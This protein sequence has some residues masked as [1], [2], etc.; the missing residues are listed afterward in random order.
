MTFNRLTTRFAMLVSM[1]M[2]LSVNLLAQSPQGTITG[3]VSDAQGARV[4]NATVNVLRVATNQKFTAVSSEEGVY[5]IPSLPIGEYEVTVTATGF[6]TYKQPKVVLEVGQRLRVDITMQ[7]GEM[8]NTVT[9][10]GDVSRVQ[11]EASSLGTTVERQRIEN[12]PLNGRHV[13]NLVKLVPGVQPRF[14]GSDGFAEVDNQSF[15]QISFNGGSAYS[16]QVFL[17]GG[18]NTVP[19]H[20]EISVVPIAD[21]VEEFKVQTNSLTAEYGQTSGGVISVATRSGTND[22]H[23]S[24]YEF[25]RNDSLDARNAFLTTR[26]PITGRIK[27]ILRYN[28]YGGTF[29][30]PLPLPRFGEGG[31]AIRSGK[32]RTFFFAGIEQWNHRQAN[33]NR[34]TVPTALERRGDFSNT[35]DGNGKLITIYDPATTRPNPNGSGFVRDPFPNNIIP[36]NRL[37]ALSLRILQYLPLPNVAPNNAFTNANN[38]LSLIG[39]PTDQFQTSLRIDHNIGEKDKIFGRYTGTK[40]TRMNRAWNNGDADTDARNDQRNNFNLILSHTHIFSNTLINELRVNGTRQF[41]DF[42]HPSF[43]KGYPAQLGFPA[44]IPQDA[45]PAII[46]DGVLPFGSGRGGFAG[47]YRRQHT[48]QVA[49]SVTWTK[50]AHVFKFGTDQR[51]NRFNFANRV[52]PSGSFNFSGSL[53]NNPLVPA[54]SG[55]GFASYLLGEVSG[56]SLS[57]R[58]FFA[59]QTASNGSFIQDDWKVTRRL[60]LNLGVRYDYATGPIER[61]NRSSN[62]DPFVINPLTNTPGALL[63]AGVTKDTHFTTPPRDNFGPRVGFAW[64]VKGDGKTAIRGGFGLIYSGIESGDTAGD[65]ANSLGFSI[66]TT[67]VAA[68]G[69]PVKAF[70]FSVGPPSLLQPRGSAGGP[71][72]F[73]GQNV[74]YQELRQPTPY[75]QQWN[76]T[77]QRELPGKWVLAATYAGNH[78]VHLFGGNYDLNQLDPKY[79]SLGLTL[80]DQVPNPYVGIIKAG[81]LSG[82]TVARSQ[83]LRP[84]PDYLNVALLANHGASSTYH[85]FQFTGERRYSNGLSALVS[86]TNSKLI[87][88]SFSIAGGGGGAGD[89]RIGRLNRKQDRAIDEEDI[90]QRLVVSAVYELPFG[91]GRRFVQGGFVSHVIGG[92]QINTITTLQT[93]RPLKVR[94]ANNFTG[95]N[96]PN[97]ACD[98]T[99]PSGD[100]TANRWFKTECFVN[101]PN[102]VIGNVPRTL[103]STRGPGYK[104]VAL[105]FFR[106]E[107][108]T[109]KVN[110]EFRAEAFNA[111]NF[112]NYDDPNTSFTPNALGVNSNANFG[113]IT[114]SLPARRIQLGLRL[115]F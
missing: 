58:P 82:A 49:D 84:F 91:K 24:L 113:K 7:V 19:V 16:N 63:Y 56:G 88:D 57:S 87:D 52:N 115:S 37:D 20:N 34:A 47:G 73:R 48:V 76:L 3:T 99:L 28:Q 38:Y 32:D 17:D 50:G 89:Y 105:S 15:S 65:T 2:L 95:I 21:T 11:T 114:T 33:I 111:F 45:F 10:T 102:F 68:G 13:F 106:K 94:G 92:W 5:A 72:A 22:Y 104:D 109:E 71:S 90:S 96:W 101:P 6:S 107:K 53:T 31:P 46:V 70:Q 81:A 69:G 83:L 42:V 79:F 1:L 12:L 8:T 61:W 74:R 67:F 100:R 86:Y 80:Q 103:P 26:D 110:I 35:R 51:W 41:L 64:D 27:P 14:K 75:V 44:I 29:G 62:F 18:T 39:F 43:D 85:S 98:P 78:G 97:L 108:L 4:N 9:V 25:F 77:I 36:Q 40:N 55:V 93:G 23:G 59:F 30:G 112:V 66:D 54:G 60:T